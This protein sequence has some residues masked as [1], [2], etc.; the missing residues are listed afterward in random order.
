[1]LVPAIDLRTGRGG[2]GRGGEDRR[3]EGRGGEGERKG[4]GEGRGREG[5]GKEGRGGTVNVRMSVHVTITL[6]CYCQP[7]YVRCSPWPS[8]MWWNM[9]GLY[10]IVSQSP[11][12]SILPL[13]LLPFLPPLP[14]LPDHTTHLLL[15]H[16]QR[17]LLNDE[18]KLPLHPLLYLLSK[19]H[20]T[21]RTHSNV[22]SSNVGCVM[23]T[24][25]VVESKGG[26]EPVLLPSV[27]RTLHIRSHAVQQTAHVCNI[28]VLNIPQTQ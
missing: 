21:H 9:L 24:R 27:H 4:R 28:H 2:E 18:E 6:R 25:Q 1:M 10:I 13:P 19:V 7:T 3:G 11:L 17:Q 12:S 22:A 15:D 8:Q 23:N 20:Q 26:R 16:L 5:R 14:P